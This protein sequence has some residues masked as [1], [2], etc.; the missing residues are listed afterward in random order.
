MANKVVIL[1][2]SLLFLS[3]SRPQTASE[4]DSDKCCFKVDEKTKQIIDSD[5]KARLFHGVNIVFK[6]F[7]FHPNNGSTFDPEYSL[8]EE[9]IQF[10]SDNGFNVVRFYVAWPGVEP[11]KDQYNSTYLDVIEDFVNKLGKKGIYSILDC[12]QDL[13]SR[14]FCGEGAPDYAALYENRSIKPLPFPELF[15]QLSPFKVDPATGYPYPKDCQKHSF[16]TYYFSDA[17]GKSVQSLFDNEQ[18]IQE[19]FGLFWGKVAQKFSSNPYVLGYELLNEP[20]AGDIYSHIDQTEPSVADKK[21]LQPLYS[22]LHNAIRQYDTE[23]IIFFEPTV[24]FTS[25]PD[26]KF[27]ST[28]LT[29]GPGG[30]D[31]NDRQVY[32]YHMYCIIMDSMGQPSNAFLCDLLDE[33]LFNIRMSDLQKLSTGG[34]MTEWG[35]YTALSPGSAA[36]S[37]AL[38]LMKLADSHL[39]SWS[40]WQYKGY[41][42]FTTQS[43]T[44]EGL[45]YKN[46][47]V[48]AEK[49]KL[50]SRTYAHAVSG[51]FLNTSF[52]QVTSKFSLTFEAD[53]SVKSTT[54]CL[55]YLNE[56]LY[57]PNGYN[58]I[59]HPNASMKVFK[60]PNQV[61][62]NFTSDAIDGQAIM[63]TIDLN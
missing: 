52:D 15:P 22:K 63:V 25:L 53:T 9:D 12:H 55:I 29:E 36:M 37:D 3:C 49:L 23:H 43:D 34:F 14:K 40:Y 44:D 62:L 59:V 20:W 50:L 45:Y 61:T 51:R 10:L 42:D 19:R 21:N 26:K 27:S 41:G 4:G 6:S 1:A 58:V 46:G 18:D 30:P 48:Q 13:W 60:A 47:T 8:N 24:I 31:Y 57:Y 33:D 16:F 39:Q 38:E 11:V 5:G 32:S 7:P 28:G 54:D 35:A 2:T 17:V 56:K